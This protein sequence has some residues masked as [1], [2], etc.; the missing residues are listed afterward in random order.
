MDP[1]P[2]EIVVLS[3]FVAER[4]Q[5]VPSRRNVNNPSALPVP[6]S[7]KISK[8]PAVFVVGNSNNSEKEKCVLDDFVSKFPSATGLPA[9]SRE[10]YSDDES[11]SDWSDDSSIISNNPP[12]VILNNDQPSSS[13]A[14]TKLVTTIN[15]LKKWA[16]RTET[17]DTKIEFLKKFKMSEAAAAIPEPD[18][19]V[20]SN[21]NNLIIVRIR[22]KLCKKP[23]FLNPAG[24]VLYWYGI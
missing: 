7:E 11:K 2:P 5:P 12:S 6:G 18:E 20:D 14:F 16:A 15:F 1:K 17:N 4:L 21:H 3:N 13:R 23:S 9:V 19:P 22:R 10:T 8:A 24:S